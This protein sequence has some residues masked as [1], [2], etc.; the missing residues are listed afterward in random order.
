MK[1]PLNTGKNILSANGKYNYLN[2]I[3]KNNGNNPNIKR[4]KWAK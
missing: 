2:N 4:V 3:T 1:Q